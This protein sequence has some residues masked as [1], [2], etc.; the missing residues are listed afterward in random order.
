[1]NDSQKIESL[2]LEGLNYFRTGEYFEAHESWEELWSD[3]YLRDRRFVQG[4]IQLSVSFVHL[5][6]NNLKGAKSL[7]NKCSEKFVEFNGLQRG[8][9]IKKL[10]KE[11]NEVSYAYDRLTSSVDFN[12]DLV[13]KL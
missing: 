4:L 11:I 9:D 7:L 6:N 5:E 13:P 10:L 8:I 2:F 3:F 12:W 1:M